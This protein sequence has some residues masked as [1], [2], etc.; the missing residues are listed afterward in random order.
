MSL[1]PVYLS[2]LRL[3][4]IGRL[5]PNKQFK[6][7]KSAGEVKGDASYPP[8]AYMNIALSLIVLAAELLMVTYY[9]RLINSPS[10]IVALAFTFL[11]VLCICLVSTSFSASLADSAGR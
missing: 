9:R 6:H 2:T 3:Y 1:I 4:L 11:F 5:V 7:F 10:D 8:L